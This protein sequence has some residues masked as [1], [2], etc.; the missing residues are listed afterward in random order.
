MLL[1]LSTTIVHTVLASD[2]VKQVC[3]TSQGDFT[4]LKRD[5]VVAIVNNIHISFKFH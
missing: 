4:T 2:V 5:K 3:Y 1:Q